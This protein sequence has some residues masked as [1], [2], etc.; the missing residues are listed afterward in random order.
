MR[1]NINFDVATEAQLANKIHNKD[2]ELK[3]KRKDLVLVR[4]QGANLIMEAEDIMEK[5]GKNA[6]NPEWLQK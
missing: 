4:L 2:F 3:G 1:M 6:L 5:F